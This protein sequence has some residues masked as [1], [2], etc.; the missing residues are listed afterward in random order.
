MKGKT[1]DTFILK[2]LHALL[3]TGRHMKHNPPKGDI[4]ADYK[5]MTIDCPCGKSRTFRMFG[6]PTM[7]GKQLIEETRANDARRVPKN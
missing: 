3:W 7:I 6:V 2:N 1:V 4:S 5:H